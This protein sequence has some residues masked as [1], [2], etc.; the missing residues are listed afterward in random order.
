MRESL[1]T[2][3]LQI[4][5]FKIKH[6]FIIVR[7]VRSILI[8]TFTNTAQCPTNRKSRFIKLSSHSQVSQQEE[9][10]SIS[11]SFL[12]PMIHLWTTTQIPCLSL[13][14]SFISYSR[15]AVQ[16]LNFFNLSILSYACYCVRC[17]MLSEEENISNTVKVMHKEFR[18][19]VD[20]TRFRN[21]FM[22]MSR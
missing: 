12:S 16:Q 10:L 4:C 6:N 3:T 14:S 22:K 11:F 19:L 15:A 20:V 1:W 13:F 2:S 21:I 18:P 7:C 17:G 9:L 8:N 5:I